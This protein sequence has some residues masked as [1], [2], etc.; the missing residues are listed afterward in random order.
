MNYRQKRI[1][2]ISRELKQIGV[3]L[4][5]AQ[6]SPE[7]IALNERA[8][9]L[10]AELKN[11]QKGTDGE[12][13][14]SDQ[15][16]HRARTGWYGNTQSPSSDG[17]FVRTNPLQYFDPDLVH[18]ARKPAPKFKVGDRVSAGKNFPDQP[19]TVTIIKAEWVEGKPS[20]RLGLT[21]F[22]G[23]RYTTDFM[24]RMFN[25]Y[26]LVLSSRGGP[27]VIKSGPSTF[28]VIKEGRFR[29]QRKG[30]YPAKYVVTAQSNGTY[31]SHLL[32]LP[33]GLAPYLIYGHYFP[34][35][36]DAEAD[37]QRREGGSDGV[38]I[39]TNPQQLWDPDFINYEKVSLS[40]IKPSSSNDGRISQSGHIFDARKNPV[41]ER[42]SYKFW[43]M[44]YDQGINTRQLAMAVYTA[45]DYFQR[46]GS[47]DLSFYAKE[48][49]NYFFNQK[50]GKIK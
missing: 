5:T 8:G 37:W 22:K 34:K 27:L 10:E 9:Q 15:P 45:M 13:V 33:P 39:L 50:E 3:Q 17:V 23:W 11:L 36:V 2:E 16:S 30:E 18:D 47:G 7:Y 14:I 44:L 26:E 28:T 1:A 24:Y 49:L 19:D 4:N 31:T 41:E 40:G 12:A 25:E 46:W 29:S 48:S 38:R 42:Q 20:P 6:S 35:Q 21:P 43:K 32:V